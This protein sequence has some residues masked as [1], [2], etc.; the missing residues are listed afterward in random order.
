MNRKF[1]K[2]GVF[3]DNLSIDEQMVPYFGRHSCKMYIKGKPIRFGYKVWC[4]CSSEGYLYYFLPYSGCSDNYNK[5]VGLGADVVLRLLEC[6][7]H[8]TRH[9]IYFDNFFTSYLLMLILTE[10]K[11]AATGTVRSNRV[12]GA[13]LKTGKELPKGQYHCQLDDSNKI[14]FCRWQDNKEVTIATNFDQI[15]PTHP[16]K[17]WRKGVQGKNKGEGP[18]VTVQQPNVLYNYNKNMGGVDLHDNAALNYRINIRSKKWY[19]PLWTNALNPA[20]VNAWKLHCFAAKFTQQTPMPQKDFR[21]IITQELLLTD[22]PATSDEEKEGKDFI[23]KNLPRVS[24]GHLVTKQHELKVRRC[25]W[26]ACG[27][28]TYYLC[29]KC[30]KHYHIKCFEKAHK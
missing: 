19:W 8:P 21:V 13:K 15:E 12:G 29:E 24:G 9:A 14:M 30:N 25:Q 5:T 22:D 11:V 28:P 6:V 17:R 3:S 10:R 23:P 1:I 7:E 26:R 18:H 2:F 4:L 27:K 20:V 16:V